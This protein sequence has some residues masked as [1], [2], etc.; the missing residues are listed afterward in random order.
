MHEKPR[1]Y[2][3]LPSLASSG[4]IKYEENDPKTNKVRFK[5]YTPS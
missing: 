3:D 4:L 5:H 2:A 1:T